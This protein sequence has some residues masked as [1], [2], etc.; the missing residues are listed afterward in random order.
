MCNKTL[1]D[2]V[3][4]YAEIPI[5]KF[6]IYTQRKMVLGC[7]ISERINNQQLAQI[8]QPKSDIRYVYKIHHLFYALKKVFQ[9]KFKRNRV[10]V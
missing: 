6:D 7:R 3:I 2:Q 10:G 8:R 5:P 4:L 1:D 9:A